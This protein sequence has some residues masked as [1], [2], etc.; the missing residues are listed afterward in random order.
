MIKDS[1]MKKKFL[2]ITSRNYWWAENIYA[3][4][5]VQIQPVEIWRPLK[6]EQTEDIYLEIFIV[7]GVHHHLHLTGS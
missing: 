4:Y 2:L 3:L 5:Y 6:Y 1:K 7:R